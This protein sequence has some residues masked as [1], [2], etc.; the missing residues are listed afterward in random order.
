MDIHYVSLNSRMSVKV[1]LSSGIRVKNL[2]VFYSFWPF[3]PLF[4]WH[5]LWHLFVPHLMAF[6]RPIKEEQKNEWNGGELT[7]NVA[8]S[9]WTSCHHQPCNSFQ[10]NHYR[11]HPR[12]KTC[13]AICAY[14]QYQTRD[15]REIVRPISRKWSICWEKQIF[16][17][18]TERQAGW[19]S[20]LAKEQKQQSR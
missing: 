5:L 16:V 11:V 14:T 19:L 13:P 15:T 6:R 18:L 3:R 8:Q 7:G 1:P 17:A 9:G 20:E 10:L 4:L 2:V 12:L